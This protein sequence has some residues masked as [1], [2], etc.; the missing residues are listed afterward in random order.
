MLRRAGHGVQ[1]RRHWTA[2]ER[3]PSSNCSPWRCR[4]RAQAR[5]RVPHTLSSAVPSRPCLLLPRSS[6]A[7]SARVERLGGNRCAS[8]SSYTAANTTKLW[9]AKRA[10]AHQDRCFFIPDLHGH[11][12]RAGLGGTS[13]IHT[14]SVVPDQH[15]ASVGDAAVGHQVPAT[16]F[17]DRENRLWTDQLSGM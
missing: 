1:T 5:T 14:H 16:E 4:G 17:R 10:N 9:S 11:W 6:P 3:D 8:A 2:E 15:L 12:R 13:S 7:R